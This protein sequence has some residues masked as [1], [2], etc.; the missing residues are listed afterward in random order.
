MALIVRGCLFDFPR[1]LKILARAI[2]TFRQDGDIEL[3]RIRIRSRNTGPPSPTSGQRVHTHF[4]T[5][6]RDIV[7]SKSAR[8]HN[9]LN[10]N[11]NYQNIF[12]KKTF[13][14]AK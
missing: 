12:L 10:A 5:T 13:A 14:L 6:I 1:R 8:R 2:T 11:N 7:I 3:K 4:G 9:I